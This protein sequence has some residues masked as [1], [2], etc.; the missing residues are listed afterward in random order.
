M[1]HRRH[2]AG[3]LGSVELLFQQYALDDANLDTIGRGE[4]PNDDILWQTLAAAHA[5]INTDMPAPPTVA[6]LG[7]AG[8]FHESDDT[9]DLPVVVTEPADATEAYNA[10][11]YEDQADFTASP[12]EQD[13][14]DAT[15][16]TAAAGES[17]EPI[18]Q[19]EQLA[20]VVPIRRYR[21]TSGLIGA[22]AATLVIAGGG[23]AI[24]NA[25]PG[26]PFY[27]LRE[28]VFGSE[29]EDKSEVYMELASALEEAQAA[30]ERG[31][32]EEAQNLLNVASNLA[33]QLGEK[34]AEVSVTV[35][36][37]VFVDTPSSKSSTVTETQTSEVTVTQT[38]TA[39]VTVTTTMPQEASEPTSSTTEEAPVE[40]VALFFG[41]N[42]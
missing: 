34:Q 26:S 4:I 17:E 25:E 3:S 39:E 11:T 38:E 10:G 36:S 42:S 20:P 30:R 12:S 15:T 35:P 24:Q 21:L 19:E 27:G 22:A 5:E 32:E 33:A 18:A 40:G 8:Y 16:A 37:T 9:A 1:S 23:M 41:G 31:D 28:A 13:Y 7:M 2:R 6:D 14:D 29:E